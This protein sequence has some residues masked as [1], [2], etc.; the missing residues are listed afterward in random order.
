VNLRDQFLHW[1]R[2]RVGEPGM[3]CH[4]L[5]IEPGTEITMRWVETWGVD[6]RTGV[7]NSVTCHES[8]GNEHLVTAIVLREA[9]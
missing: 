7:V 3:Q 5:H 9:S 2:R 4:G 6:E 1:L 8:A